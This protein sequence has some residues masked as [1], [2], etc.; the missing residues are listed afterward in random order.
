MLGV[1]FA[2]IRQPRVIAEV[3]G[4]VFLGPSILGRIPGFTARIFPDAAVPMLTL[5]STIGLI[6]FLFLVGMEI[7]VR[8]V[9]RNFKAS[10]AISVAGLTVP[11][12]LGAAL[13]VGLY[14]QFINPEV[15]FGYF[16]LFCAVAVGITAF[17]VLCRILTELKLLD[18]TVGV[19]VLSAGVGND[20]VGWILLALTVALVNAGNGIDALYV[21]LTSVGYVLF[22]IYPV[23]LSFRYLAK[24]T[25]SLETGQPTHFMM[26]LTLLIVFI[27]AFFTDIIGVHPIFGGFLA[28]LIIPHDNGYAIAVVEKLED[29]VS[30][31]FLPLYF[32]L[33][34][35]RTNLG[36]LDNG[37]TWGYVV[38][39]CAVSFF[40][41]FISCFTAAKAFG[42]NLRESGAV[43]AL[44][45]CK[46]LVELIVLNVGLQAGILDT[47]TFSMFVIHAIILTFMTTPL[48]L[49]LYPKR[50]R[51]EA[52][53][54][55]DNDGQPSEEAAITGTFGGHEF[56][57][58][59]S[60]VLDKIEQL[61]AVMTFM[62][63]LQTSPSTSSSV[64]GASHSS[65]SEKA[66]VDNPLPEL[67]S[68]SATTPTPRIS[69][70][71][72]RLIELTD[73][74]S[75]VLRSQA[76]D[77]LIHSD[78]VISIFRTY[79]HLNRMNV[80]ADLKVIPSDE[81]SSSISH[82][83]QHSKSQVLILPWCRG[84][85][86]EG[87]SASNP[88][89]GVFKT[90]GQ[91]QTSSV[92]YSNFIRKVF[93]EAA[94]DVA[95]F[96]DRGISTP[97][98]AA[99]Q[100]IFLP[101]FG[102]PDD[103]LALSFVVQ[104]CAG[105]S[106]TATVVRMQKVESLP[107]ETV[108]TIEQEKAAAHQNSMTIAETVY[109]QGNTQTR[110]QSDTAD[111]LIWAGYTNGSAAYSPAVT[112][113]LSRIQFR[114]QSS[115]TPLHAVVDTAASEIQRNSGRTLIA[116][117]GRSR[118]LAPDSHE[119]ELRKII[120]ERGAAGSQSVARTLGPAGAALV[121]ASTNASLLVMQ[122]CLVGM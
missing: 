3:I 57:T 116:V 38:L 28:G 60:V 64:T 104:L 1:L 78:P 120:E 37:I 69:V 100:H 92:I 46:G 48:T 117:V 13:G 35:L 45:S 29:L 34:G 53:A 98:Q 74:T 96:V 16:V 94:T 95:L 59:F 73:R 84:R 67:H 118:R 47:R 75:A 40:S 108:D 58:K 50:Y 51:V 39:I 32:T 36:L 42:F 43:G 9:R 79:G 10:L 110:L 54:I 31:I 76:S 71:A 49:L 8:V 61:P 25:G 109:G 93:L 21:L 7:D 106:V 30:I 77:T 12:G 17:P 99:S 119:A 41:K 15:N 24:R 4:G 114:T 33:S 113:S 105:S 11:L 97:A 62:Q 102:G 122:A 65:I 112:A 86:E 111:N 91:D 80:S 52:A 63:L 83:V 23:R 18:T 55:R 66:P 26:T 107:L 22:L 90:N 85:V 27:S 72:L 89:D 101:F 6:L 103:R 81:F 56:K 121:A 88:F 70:D 5:T 19:V 20:I 82:H 115:P 14:R 2:R 87:P 44:M 68:S